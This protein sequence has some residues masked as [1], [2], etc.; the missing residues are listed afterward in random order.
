MKDTK[1]N[2]TEEQQ[3]KINF[4]SL[5]KYLFNDYCSFNHRKC[6]TYFLY[7]E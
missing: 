1:D 5:R 7:D 4:Q 2:Q 6:H 3:E